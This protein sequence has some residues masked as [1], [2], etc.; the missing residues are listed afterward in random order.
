MYRNDPKFLDRQVW[1]NRVDPDQTLV[2]VCTVCYS[3]CIY[4]TH[5]SIVN[6]HC[7]IRGLITAIFSGVQSFRMFTVFHCDFESIV[8]S[9]VMCLGAVVRKR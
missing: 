6:L 1:A 4:W 2:R 3:V 8:V 7:S 5:Y 9:H